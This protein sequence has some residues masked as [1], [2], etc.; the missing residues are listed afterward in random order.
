MDEAFWRVINR[1]IHPE[2]TIADIDNLFIEKSD[3][4][5]SSIQYDHLLK[6]SDIDGKGYDDWALWLKSH[7]DRDVPYYGSVTGEREMIRWNT[8]MI[9]LE[10]QFYFITDRYSKKSGVKVGLTKEQVERILGKPNTQSD[11]IWAY[12]TGDYLTFWLFFED[13]KVKYM[14]RRMPA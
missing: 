5:M 12:L 9:N 4:G 1:S 13:D 11:A 6:E 3:Q 8:D 14:M 2:S 7:S 10:L